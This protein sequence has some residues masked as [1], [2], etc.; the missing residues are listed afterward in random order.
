MLFFINK[1]ERVVE[2][3]S[4]QIS[5]DSDCCSIFESLQEIPYIKDLLPK[6]PSAYTVEVIQK[7]S[8]LLVDYALV[9]GDP[10]RRVWHEITE[11]L[12]VA[13][14]KLGYLIP[15]HFPE[16][17]Q[18]ALACLTQ[19]QK[20]KLP[21]PP[22]AL[23]FTYLTGDAPEKAGND[24]V[25]TFNAN[26]LFMP[27]DYTWFFGGVRR[28]EERVDE[29]SAKILAEDADVVSLQEMHTVE[30]SYVL[31]ERLKETYAHFYINIGQADLTQDPSQIR[32]NS[33]L[34]VASKYPIQ[35]P[36]FVPFT[37]D[38]R[39]EGINKGFFHGTLMVG[40]NPFCSIYHTHL[41]PFENE[42][43]CQVRE[44]EAK[45]ILSSMNERDLFSILLGDLNVNRES[46]EWLSS[47]LSQKFICN[48]PP[49][50]GPT[51]TDT[52]GKY[53]ETPKD[54]RKNLQEEGHTCDYALLYQKNSEAIL[55]SRQIKFY[56]LND[57]EH[58]LS[59]HQGLFSIITGVTH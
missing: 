45:D 33:G 2:V 22:S 18:E 36:E 11:L 23:P 55:Q 39:Q 5:L 53:V 25:T 1:T 14:T 6:N 32:M 52:L 41:N 4:S 47:P 42:L 24:S 3:T 26:I 38:G 12:Q 51:C 44:E 7:V 57:P 30:G 37:A 34:F 59:D 10:A 29:V 20:I 54:M 16:K 43:A 58:A 48:Y 8:N 27:D 28:W 50:E 15:T 40:G 13:G 46:A 9:K 21:P 49:G 19:I 56:D 35:G 17:T 31:Y